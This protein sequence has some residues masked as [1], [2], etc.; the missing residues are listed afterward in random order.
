MKFVI[1]TA[2]S[3]TSQF[4]EMARTRRSRTASTRSRSPITSR[5]PS[6]IASRY[7]YTADGSIRWTE[8]TA[9]PDPWVSIGAM[10]AV[11]TR[12]ALRHQHLRARAAQPVPRGQGDRDR[13]GALGRSRRARRRRRLV[14]GRVRALRPGLPHARQAHRRDDR[15]DAQALE[16]RLRR[17]RRALL[18]IRSRAHAARAGAPSADLRRRSLGARAA[19]RR[20]PRRLD[21]RSPHQRR[22]RRDRRDAA[23]L[24]RRDRSRE[25]AAST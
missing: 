18:P 21:L 22:A 1:P 15:G 14:Q 8:D 11:T 3:P 9:W 19:P 23:P 6:T 4:C 5:I 12:A 16:R 17:A 24:P 20:A 2:F 7:P 25:R 13:G 10:A